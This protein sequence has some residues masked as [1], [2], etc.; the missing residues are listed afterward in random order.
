MT[1]LLTMLTGREQNSLPNLWDNKGDITPKQVEAALFQCKK[2]NQFAYHH[3]GTFYN[4]Q[5]DGNSFY[6][7]GRQHPEYVQILQIRDLRDVFVSLVY[8]FDKENKQRWL[9]CGISPDAPFADK[10]TVSIQSLLKT[11]I[12]QAMKW[13][14]DPNVVVMR[15]EDLVGP[16][17]GG[18]LKAQEQAIVT[19]ANALGIALTDQ[20]L[21]QVTENLFGTQ[22]GPKTPTTFNSGQTGS[23]RKHYNEGH[24]R[25]FNATWGDHQKTLGYP[26]A[27]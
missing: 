21:Q 24:K 14:K 12:N 25:L 22:K 20:R 7:F 3:T 19:L 10:L 9:D 18:T 4:R 5:Y 13:L 2:N 11:D 16:S 27:N 1:K 26:L 17:G 8:Y 15:F 23:W 6:L